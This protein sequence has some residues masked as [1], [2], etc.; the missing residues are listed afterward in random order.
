MKF[1]NLSDKCLK[2]VLVR[3]K[4]QKKQT[5]VGQVSLS[6]QLL[7][8]DRGLHEFGRT[9]FLLSTVAGLGIPPHNFIAANS[10]KLNP[11]ALLSCVTHNNS[12]LFFFFFF[13][14]V[15]VFKQIIHSAR[16]NT[17]SYSV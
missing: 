9:L 13:P 12:C 15:D 17:L 5:V 16:E 1:S 8:A 11:L 4:N 7:G 3:Q 10:V 14:A 6:F 2:S